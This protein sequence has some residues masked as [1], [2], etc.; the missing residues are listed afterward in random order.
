T[1]E[2]AVNVQTVAAASEELSSSI[3]EISRQ[4]SDSANVTLEAVEAAESTNVT[5]EGLS[6]AGAKIG[7]VVHLISD[8]ASQTNL[9]AL[10][11]TIEAARAGESGKGFAVVASEVKNL[12]TQTAQATEEISNEISAMQE[13][14]KNAVG[15]I[16][17]ITGVIGKINEITTSISSAVEEQSAA[18]SEISRNA[19]EASGGTDEVTKNVA[20]VSDSTAATG[21]AATQVQA[22]ASELSMQSETLKQEVESFLSK[23]RAV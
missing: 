22:A 21:E 11:A 6:E 14:T 19:Q 18:T 16:D 17:R 8:I 1:E 12:A 23:I 20:G 7:E 9:L 13:Q 10:N 3:S 2:A 15:A 5:M 4:V